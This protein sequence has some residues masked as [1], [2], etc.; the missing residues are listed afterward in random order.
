MITKESAMQIYNLYSQ[1]EK[2]NEIIEVLTKC[3]EQYEKDNQGV[4]IIRDNWNSH[5][6]IELHIPDRFTNP[7]GSFFGGAT[8]YHISV[9]DAILV[10]ENHVVRLHKSLENEMKKAMEE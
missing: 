8:I 5:Q 2:S 10:L 6:S 4:E 3:K 1:I 9:P 7:K